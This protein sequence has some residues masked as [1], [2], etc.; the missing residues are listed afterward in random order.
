MSLY[1]PLLHLE[2]AIIGERRVEQ[3]EGVGELRL[4]EQA[5]PVAFADA[6][7]AVAHSPTPST[8]RIAAS[9]NGL[10]K[11]ALA[12]WLSWCSVKT[13]LCPVGAP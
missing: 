12:A 11:N 1:S 10:G 5:N 2:S 13:N 6:I 7:A 8:V 4:A 9:S 3:A